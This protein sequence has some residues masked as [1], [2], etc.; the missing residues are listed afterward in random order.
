M[1]AVAATESRPSF[2]SLHLR[3][4]PSKSD[5]FIS[6]KCD[7][8]EFSA[9]LAV[10][11]KLPVREFD[12][13]SKKW[14]APRTQQTLDHLQKNLGVDLSS[15]ALEKPEEWICPWDEVEL[16]HSF[17][18]LRSYQVD[19]LKFMTYRMGRGL[20]ADEMG[21]GKTCQ[22][23][24]W[25]EYSHAYPALI[26]TTANTKTQWEREIKKWIKR[27]LRVCVLQGQTAR[28][29]P[30]CD[31]IICNWDI[32]S[33]HEKMLERANLQLLIGDEVHL[34]AN[35]EAKRTKAF[36][37]LAF[38]TRQLI[39][40]T[41]SPIRTK[42][43]QFFPALHM[44]SPKEFKSYDSFKFRYCNP[45]PSG[46]GYKFEGASNTEEL[47]M[48]VRNVMIRRLK[49]DVMKE[50]PDK[51]RQIVPMQLSADAAAL[52]R[53]ETALDSAADA[54]LGMM[55]EQLL[56]SVFEFKSKSIIKWI[57]E[58]FEEED[59]LLIFVWNRA[60][61][62]YLQEQFKD[63]CVRVDGSTSKAVRDD[64][65]RRFREDDSCRLFIG[66]IVA[67]GVGIDGLQD[68]CS[69]VAFAQFAMSPGDMA[70]AEDRLHRMGQK[71]CVNVYYLAGENSI[72]ETH[73]EVLQERA[74]DIGR[75]L[76]GQASDLQLH[77]E[78]MSRRKSKNA[79]KK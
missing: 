66:N 28:A 30:N 43:Q 51:I 13:V 67:A 79:K 11:K 41:G 72:D 3:V 33:Y 21:T 19:F 71:S 38:L 25:M 48:K 76:E 6:W 69:H 54:H 40:L 2:K 59:K 27:D 37:N 36:S 78:V 35:P 65:V 56:G 34:V 57:N 17:D 45:T 4:E 10:V 55:Y 39:L 74:A 49:K 77:K 31:V 23:L 14:K 61:G 16:Q 26:V 18:Y 46:F 22:A 53:M 32:L 63:S 24:T 70:Q 42:P 47:H 5:F 62:T 58:F 15:I 7:Q 1:I 75:I 12:A 8:S 44:L 73:I 20:N 60:V 50:L 9:I 52:E 29:I 64:A 68:V